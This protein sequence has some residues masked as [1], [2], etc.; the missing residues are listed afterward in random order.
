MFEVEHI[1]SA[2]T[3]V[4]KLLRPE[5]SARAD[6]IERMQLE[7][8]ALA[9]LDHPNVVQVL[10]FGLL[11]NGTP[12]LVLERLTGSTLAQEL[13]IRGY[14]AVPLAIDYTRQALAGLAA[15][16]SRGIVHR[17]IKPD[18]LFLHTTREAALV[19]KIF[20]F[21]IAKVVETPRSGSLGPGITTAEG[22]MVG[23]PRYLSPE[24]A[25]GRS[26][27]LRSDIYSAGLVLYTMLTGRGPFDDLG[28]EAAIA[29]A[30][31]SQHP[32]PPSRYGGP[33]I[34]PELDDA[35]LKALAKDPLDRFQSAD[36]FRE[37]LGYI[38]GRLPPPS[39]RPGNLPVRRSDPITFEAE[40]R[41]ES[42]RL[43]KKHQSGPR[44]VRGPRRWLRQIGFVALALA[45]VLMSALLARWLAHR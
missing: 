28:R 31:I 42:A 3:C 10:D 21:G 17:D 37:V 16:H 1:P 41:R 19:I 6:F 8:H 5:L 7:A 39:V 14:L 11:P 44:R 13:K 2:V 38:A 22:S 15:A 25:A 33:S 43:M 45:V 9:A 32:E 27:D 4:L 34:P 12:Y 29:A 40:S 24:Q 30:H 26:V 20:D 18:N 36:E 35:V 23:T